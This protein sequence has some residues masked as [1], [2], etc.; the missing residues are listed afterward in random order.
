MLIFS[1]KSKQT[2][3]IC[4]LPKCLP[5]FFL[6]I[7]IIESFQHDMLLKWGPYVV[8]NHLENV[9]VSNFG[10]ESFSVVEQFPMLLQKGPLTP[11]A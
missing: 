9:G 4:T 3:T 2:I 10:D 5:N 8:K 11:S 7:F 1:S 6:H